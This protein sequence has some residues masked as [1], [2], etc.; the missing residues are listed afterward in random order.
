MALISVDMRKL[1]VAVGVGL[2]VADKSEVE[3]VVGKSGVEVVVDES[4][5]VVEV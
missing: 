5:V 2:K 3:V 1:S 4:G